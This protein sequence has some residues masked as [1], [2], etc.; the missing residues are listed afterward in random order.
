MSNTVS[1]IF[2]DSQVQ[3]DF[4]KNGYVKIKL[5]DDNDVLILVD[6][7]Q[8]YFPDPSKDFYSSSYDNN[9]ELKKRMSDEIGKIVL[10][11][12][13]GLFRDFTWFGS[14][15]LSKGNGPR[16][17]MPMHQDWTIV[18]EKK[19]VALNIWTPLQSTDEENGTI[20][21]IPGSHRWHQS[22][23]APTLPFYYDGFQSQLKTALRPVL[24]S[25][26][27]AVVLNQGI[28]HYS[29]ANKTDQT[30]IA[31]TTGIKSGDAPMLFHYWD[32][33]N[34]ER[35]EIF[36]QENDFLIRFEN[37]HQAIFKRPLIGKS[38]GTK[39]FILP[40]VSQEEINRLVGKSSDGPKKKGLVNKMFQWIRG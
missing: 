9:Y 35:I 12:L 26:G 36:E 8:Q 38:I 1:P 22:L 15:F 25:V 13:N 40:K 20:E 3:D 34:P 30:R 28:I 39:P 16:S 11:R 29:K 4:E 18:D 27:E 14:A 33:T 6:L 7:F 37:F 23:R 32:K 5:L 21:V 2:F 24:A 31:I 17:E 19:H 10:P